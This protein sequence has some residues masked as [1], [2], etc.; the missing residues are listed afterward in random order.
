MDGITDSNMSLRKLQE[1]VRQGKLACCRPWGHKES[2]R[3]GQL[4]K[5][6]NSIEV[7]YLAKFIFDAM[8]KAV[9]NFYFSII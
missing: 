8:A 4:N 2:E 5:N 1:M 9:L 6:K 7:I 3:T